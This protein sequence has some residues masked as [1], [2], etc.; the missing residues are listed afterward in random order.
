VQLLSF[1]A[2]LISG[3]GRSW[4]QWDMDFAALAMLREIAKIAYAE[5]VEIRDY[6]P[7]LALSDLHGPPTDAVRRR[8]LRAGERPQGRL[9][10]VRGS[11][12]QDLMSDRPPEVEE[13]F[14]DLCIRAERHGISAPWLSLTLSMGRALVERSTRVQS[15]GARAGSS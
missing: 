5:R 12:L 9:G 2:G 8:I 3:G 6:P 15:T 13:I 10:P 1:A 14:G 11:M 7:L 4:A